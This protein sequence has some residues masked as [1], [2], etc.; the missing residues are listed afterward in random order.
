MEQ[1]EII[2]FFTLK[3]L[4]ARE[5]QTEL[6]SLYGPEALALSTVRKWCKRFQ[7]GRTDLMDDPRSE[8]PVTDDLVETT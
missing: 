1:R 4:K 7:E 8:K 2:R 5:I 6:E 3:V